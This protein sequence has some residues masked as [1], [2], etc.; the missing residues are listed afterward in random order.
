ML[1]PLMVP[2]HAGATA[3]CERLRERLAGTTE[4]IGTTDQAR[5]YSGAITRQNFEIRK[6]RSD[7]RRLGCSSG[8]I[9]VVDAENDAACRDMESALERMEDNKSL[10]MQKRNDIS[11]GGG[12]LNEDARR[13][14]LTAIDANGC[15][16][17]MQQPDSISADPDELQPLPGGGETFSGSSF[18]QPDEGFDGQQLP[19]LS[20]D[21]GAL[22]TLCVRT[23][24]GS[25]FPISSN[26]TPQSFPHDANVCARMCPGTQTELYYHSIMTQ[27]S[28]DM[29]S[30]QTG[31]P[32]TELPT[33]FSYRNRPIGEKSACSC[34]LSSYYQQTLRQENRQPE[35][36]QA[37]TTI[38]AKAKAGA[39]A[40]AQ[41]EQPVEAGE[42]P[43]DP[44]N[45]K[46]RQVGP[47]FL[48][49][50]TVQLDLKNPSLRGAQPVQ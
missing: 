34:N 25:F 19:G 40:T 30:A 49:D 31:K 28:A 33:A 48:A 5:Q 15:N 39:D 29:V 38:P 22:R 36:Y 14:I 46:V 11:N 1:V 41:A 32:Y 45:S 44:L 10:L 7:L 21:M 17:A 42:R 9:I 8:S 24:D 26:A 12:E 43:Y 13:R 50:D 20:A 23:C 2:V 18:A 3:L 16:E 35:N 47:R 27:E 4:V 6:T 37:I